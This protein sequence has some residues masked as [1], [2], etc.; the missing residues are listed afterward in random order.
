MA[1]DRPS[2]T[3]G[4]D[5]PHTTPPRIIA[6]INQ[7]GGVGKTTTTV[8][9]AAALAGKGRRVLIV[10]LDPQA[11]ASL[12]LGVE[13]DPEVASLYDLLLDTAIDPADAL[14]EARDGLFVLPSD[15]DLAAAE[16]ELGTMPDRH[17]RLARIL[18]RLHDRAEYV[19][20]DCPPSL[21]MLTINALVAAADVI[22]PMQAQFLALQGVG[23][24][25][26]TITLVTQNL[27]PSLRV[28][29]VVLCMFDGKTTHAQEV[30]ADLEAFFSEQRDEASPWRYARVYQPP[31]RRNVKV[32]ECPSF[33]QSIFEYAPTA[34]GARD[35]ARLADELI[36]E[37]EAWT[38]DRRPPRTPVIEKDAAPAP[39]E[40]P[41]QAPS[42]RLAAPDPS[43][44]IAEIV[45]ETASAART[46]VVHTPPPQPESDTHKSAPPPQANPDPPAVHVRPSEPTR[47]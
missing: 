18:E 20:I 32:A 27:N 6:M 4:Q 30:V 28:A 45:A 23:K 40:I 24:L 34:A 44:L 2:D 14:I 11:H 25:L 10:D 38:R 1:T 22:I 35:Y 21:G 29:G 46:E 5:A 41:T 33:G 47:H 3:T 39:A 26:E 9:L 16:G 31:I 17:A 19:L 8:N 36:R 43:T 15:T 13:P 37:W 7:K 42:P 12:H